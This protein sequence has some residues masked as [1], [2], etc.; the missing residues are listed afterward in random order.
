MPKTNEK[1]PK[2]VCT[3][4]QMRKKCKKHSVFWNKKE[5]IGKPEKVTMFSNEIFKHV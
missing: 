3:K 2:S 4:I 1:N 5:Q